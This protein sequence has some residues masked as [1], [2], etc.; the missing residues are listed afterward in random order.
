MYSDNALPKQRLLQIEDKQPENE[1]TT[2]GSSCTDRVLPMAIV[3]LV[4]RRR[5]LKGDKPGTC[6]HQQLQGAAKVALP[7]I[8]PSF[9][10]ENLV[11][12]LRRI[13]DAHEPGR[14]KARHDLRT[15]QFS[16]SLMPSW[17]ADPPC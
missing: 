16:F 7:R 4:L 15:G 11:S 3:K 12:R 9:V 1:A 14:E 5:V 8:S 2:L 10:R 17:A 13:H 6:R